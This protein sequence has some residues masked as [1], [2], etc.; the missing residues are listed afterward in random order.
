LA[1]DRKLRFFTIDRGWLGFAVVSRPGA[2]RVNAAHAAFGPLLNAL[3][4]MLQKRDGKAGA[5][6]VTLEQ[7]IGIYARASRGRFGARARLKTQERIEL[8]AKN[9]DLEGAKVHEQV[10]Q[11]ILHLEQQSA[12]EAGGRGPK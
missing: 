3:S 8:L 4:V 7:S 12:P 6:A 10:M 9:G 11:Q 1:K 5:M 2:G